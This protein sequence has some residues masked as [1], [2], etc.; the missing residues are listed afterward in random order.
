MGILADVRKMVGPS[1]DY[2]YFDKDLIFHI[3]NAFSILHQLGISASGGGAFRITGN[4]EEWADLLGDNPNLEMIKDYVYM[5][6]RQSFDPPTS[7]FVL[8]SLEQQIKE[9][10]WRINVEVDPGGYTS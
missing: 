9:L 7:S 6:T 1:E 4:T 8:T 3:N 5:K 10:E 2:E